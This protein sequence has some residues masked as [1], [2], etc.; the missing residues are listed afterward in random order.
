MNIFCKYSNKITT[1]VVH[2]H[3]NF[4]ESKTKNFLLTLNILLVIKLIIIYL[5]YILY[6]IIL[7]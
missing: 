7:Y 5:T 1:I 6:I 3:I 4:M 2:I